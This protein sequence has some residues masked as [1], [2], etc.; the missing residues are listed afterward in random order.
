MKGWLFDAYPSAGKM[1]FWLKQQDGRCVRLE[2]AWT[3]SIFLA[4]DDRAD[5]NIPLQCPDCRR[6]VKSH[7]IV[8]KYERIADPE[9]SWVLRFTLTDSSNAV[10]LAREIESHG[11]F[12]RFRLYNVDLL[13]AQAYLYEHDLFPLALC[14]VTAGDQL[15]WELLDDVWATD[16]VIPDFRTIQLDIRLKKE[17]ALPKFSDRLAA[18]RIKDKEEEYEISGDSEAE[19]LKGLESEVERLDPDIVFTEHGDAFI[20]PYILHRAGENGVSLSLGREKGALKKSAKEGTSY[21][22]YGKIHFKPSS[23]QLKGR[24]HIDISNSFSIDETGL[25]G[26][27]EVTRICRM[28]LHT[29]SRASIG[30]CLS[31]LQFYQ[32]AKSDML[33]PWKPS[34][35]EH[36]KTYGE[37]LVADRGGFI[38]EPRT[39]V[40]ENVAEFDFASLYPSIMYQ[41]NISAETVRCKC[42]PDSKE[43]VPELGYNICEKRQGVVPKA[44]KIVIEKRAKYKELIKTVSGKDREVYDARQT[45][46][47]WINVATFGYLGFNNAKFGRIDAHIAVCAFDR[48]VFLQATRIAERQ[49]F[50]ILHGIV[51]SLWIQKRGATERDYV[52][53][54]SAVKEE[55]EFSMSFEGVYKWIVF[56]QSKE[57]SDLPA[58]NRYFG[59]F[60]DGSVKI[61]GIEARRHDTPPLFTRFQHKALG[62]M[63]KGDSISEVKSLMP[64]VRQTFEHFAADIRSGR[65]AIEDLVFTKQ[66]SKDAGQYH[67]RNTIENNSISQLFNEGKALKAGQTLRYVITDYKRRRT[68]PVEL[69]DDRTSVDVERYIELLAEACNSLTAY[70]GFKTTQK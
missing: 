43:R 15:Q 67:N 18:A 4:V 16:Y 17:G 45:A 54:K 62:I 66:L 65:V 12:S 69:I 35:A 56:L 40:F 24:V 37:L 20:F 64:E 48:T 49:G 57:N 6:Y 7:N 61:R 19:I 58:A 26:L 41:K 2:D 39:G 47:K 5:F 32:A 46:L 59:A 53:L 22:S 70:F 30:K 55:T 68:V 3:H 23:V 13:P 34:V 28:P 9:T 33:I 42:C 8:Q 10:K 52:E 21:F 50:R 36:F 1:V 60:S 29:S 14:N 51:D 31:S 63:A 44:I 11:N 38:F 27:Y 25:Q